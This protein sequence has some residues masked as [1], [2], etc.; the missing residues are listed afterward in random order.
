[1]IAQLH[2]QFLAAAL[3]LCS[4]RRLQTALS[5]LGI[6]VGVTGLILVIAIGEGANRE[7]QGALGSGTVIV[8]NSTEH[9]DQNALT[10]AKAQSIERLSKSSLQQVVPV[11]NG[12]YDVIANQ[13]A[14]EQVR[15][16]GTNRHFRQFYQKQMHSGRFLT[17]Y[18]VRHG[19]RVCV[20][21][22]KAGKALF[23][24]GQVIGQ[25]VRIGRDWYEVVGWLGN[26]THK[27]PELESLNLEALEQLVYLPISAALFSDRDNT[28][29]ELILHFDSE[30]NMMAALP[31]V[32][33]VVERSLNLEGGEPAVDYIIPIQLLRD[34]Q[35][36][37]QL[38]QYLLFGIAAVMLLVGGVG[39]MNVMMFNVISRKAEIGLRRAIGATRRDIIGQFLT[40]S[41]V[42]ALFGGIAGIILGLLLSVI[43]DIATS[44][45]MV[46]NVGAA[47]MGFAASLII[48]GLFGS[49]PALQAASVSPV[50]SL[51]E[52]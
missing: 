13:S 33:R 32:Q 6:T 17:D 51:Q 34:K 49:Y 26:T 21:G 16:V 52:Q 9:N 15:V 27:M 40:E 37:Q 48:G 14:V 5:T 25:Q 29:D 10:L 50:K 45:H 46:F 41:M 44:W 42:I 19:T 11:R 28:V 2:Y 12:L 4:K 47:F 31:V 24:R 39:R 3:K 30:T 18:D 43:I 20:L 38:F 7:L 8:R 23:S 22:W 35:K 36:V 1:M